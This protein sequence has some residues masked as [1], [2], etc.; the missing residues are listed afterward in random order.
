MSEILL[1]EDNDESRKSTKEFL[2][3]SKYTVFE[4][5]TGREAIIEAEKELPDLIVCDISLSA[6]DELDNYGILKILQKNDATSHIPFII[7]TAK[8]WDKT[9]FRKAMELGATD[10][11]SKPF[12]EIELLNAIETQLKKAESLKARFSKNETWLAKYKDLDGKDLMKR[13]LD[14]SETYTYA[15]NE[16][17]YRENTRPKGIYYLNNGKV[18]ISKPND[19]GKELIHSIYARGDFFGFIPTLHKNHQY[20]LS[21]IAIEDSEVSL[22]PKDDFFNLIFNNTEASQI[23]IKLLTDKLREKDEQ[24]TNLAYNS[25]RKKVADAL[26]VLHEKYRDDEGYPYCISVS[27]KDLADLAGV[28]TETAIRTLSEFKEEKLIKTNANKI[29]ILEFDRLKNMRN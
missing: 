20:Y 28:A 26:V 11:L 7:I 13:L 22:I 15:K 21:A 14:Q 5:K 2:Q 27:R 24:L 16:E 6:P 1:I 19:Y 25:V 29:C 23:F 8:K 12:N 10:Y 18:K 9:D 3:L 4:V 17:I